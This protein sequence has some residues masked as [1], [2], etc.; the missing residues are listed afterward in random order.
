MLTLARCP[1][2]PVVAPSAASSSSSS[3]SSAATTTPAL[4]LAIPAVKTLYALGPGLNGFARVLHGGIVAAL[5]DETMGVLLTTNEQHVVLAPSLPAAT[6]V[7]G[8]G[9]DLVSG[10]A[11]AR[12]EENRRARSGGTIDCVTASMSVR[13]RAPVRTPAAAVVVEAKVVRAEGRRLYLTAELSAEGKLCAIGEA[14]FVR[15]PTER[16]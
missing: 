9:S 2:V 12:R 10:D 16:L 8:P 6:A 4:T 15:V 7:A 5:L 1:G 3:A 11:D 14:V 13:F